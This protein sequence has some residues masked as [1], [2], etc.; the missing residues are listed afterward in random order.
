[1][2]KAAT[3]VGAVA[4][5]LSDLPPA[6]PGGYPDGPVEII[7]LKP[8]TVRVGVE[9]RNVEE[10]TIDRVTVREPVGED[11]FATDKATGEAEKAAR[12]IAQLTD[13]PF[14]FV[15]RMSAWDFTTVGATVARF[16]P[17]GD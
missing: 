12:L 15:K 14:Q 6:A 11:L 7:L 10:R 5:I 9:G 2:E 4:G 13:Q 17:T 16:F 3:A 1:M 8:V